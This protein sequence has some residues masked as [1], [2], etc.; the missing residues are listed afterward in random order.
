MHVT[1]H[2]SMRRW[3]HR[4]LAH[5]EWAHTWCATTATTRVPSV[6][7]WLGTWRLIRKSDLTSV[8]SARACSRQSLLCRTTSTLT[9]ESGRSTARLSVN[10]DW[11][12]CSWYNA[13]NAMLWVLFSVD[14]TMGVISRLFI[15]LL[16]WQCQRPSH[17]KPHEL[18]RDTF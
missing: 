9:L 10:V 3:I 6:T 17:L 1:E 12:T 16:V 5:R 8:T 15:V 13:S 7:Y 18:S 4:Q 2:C 11:F 14:W